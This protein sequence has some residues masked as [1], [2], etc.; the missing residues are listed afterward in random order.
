V[1]SKPSLGKVGRGALCAGA[2]LGG[3]AAAHLGLPVSPGGPIRPAASAAAD[4]IESPVP[5]GFSHLSMGT[6]DAPVRPPDDPDP[7]GRAFRDGRVITGATPHRIILFTFDDGPDQR[8]TPR[9]LDMLD[10][11]GIKAVFFVTTNRF[12]DPMPWYRRNAEL[13]REIARRGHLVGNHTVDHEEL[14][15]LDDAGVVRELDVAAQ[16]IEET[17]GARPWLLRPPGGSRS[18]RVDGIAAA[19]GYTTM[20][21]N[22]GAGDFQVKS[23][24]DVFRTFV[25]VLERREREDGHRGGV[26]LLHDTYPHTVE[27]FPRIVRWLR[28]RNCELLERGEELYDFVG[29]PSFFF[30]PRG[31]ASPSAEAAAAELAP[32]VLAFR[33]ERL[34]E[35]T[36]RRC[37]A[38]DPR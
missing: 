35:D 14:P 7:T 31:S 22:I 6:L 37:A 24:D 29:D 19:R 12:Q 10:E 32:D 23:A 34:R 2:L 30:V 11:E 21:W 17:L 16:T 36:R 25:R 15:A 13:V 33:Q 4:S 8:T 3:A 28:E 20:L 26:V 38:R 18:P 9:L 5:A 27:A 1:G